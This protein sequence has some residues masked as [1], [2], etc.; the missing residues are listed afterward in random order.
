MT[1][2]PGFGG[3]SFRHDTLPKIEWINEQ[4]NVR[5]LNFRLEVDGG[6]DTETAPLCKERGVDTFVAGSAFFKAADKQAFKNEITQ[7]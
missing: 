1:V 7:A 4:R 5:N 6:L 3:Q 2:Q